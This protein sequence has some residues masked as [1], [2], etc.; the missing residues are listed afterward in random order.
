LDTG[1]AQIKAFAEAFQVPIEL[2]NAAYLEEGPSSYGPEPNGDPLEIP[3]A[4]VQPQRI[5]LY[6]EHYY[7]LFPKWSFPH[8]R[9]FTSQA[10]ASPDTE[11]TRIEVTSHPVKVTD[12]SDSDKMDDK[13]QMTDMPEVVDNPKI[14]MT[15]D[16]FNTVDQLWDFVN[17]QQSTPPKISGNVQDKP[18]KSI[19]ANKKKLLPPSHEAVRQFSAGAGVAIEPRPRIPG[20]LRTVA[21]ADKPVQVS[22]RP[23]PPI[24]RKPIAPLAIAAG[25]AV[26]LTGL[27]VLGTTI[28]NI[29]MGKRRKKEPKKRNVDFTSEG[30]GS[31]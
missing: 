17:T 10:D 28:V 31:V 13:L 12:K 27:F 7:P 4:L 14:M 1:E 26:G 9:I 23:F 6:E 20:P 29:I 8:R 24:L 5:L 18:L 25:V 2:T 11:E 21:T 30:V 19:S 22:S 3:A 15:K 16:D